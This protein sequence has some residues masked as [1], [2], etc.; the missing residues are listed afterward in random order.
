MRPPT[1]PPRVAQVAHARWRA[2]R[3]TTPRPCA[4]GATPTSYLIQRV[5]DNHIH[6]YVVYTGSVRNRLR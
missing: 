3:V 4:E 2:K 1:F 5:E 6:A